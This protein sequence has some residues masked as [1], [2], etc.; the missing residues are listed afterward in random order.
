MT[1]AAIIVSCPK[2]GEPP[3][4]TDPGA[5]LEYDPRQ[6]RP[7]IG[8]RPMSDPKPLLG[9][10]NATNRDNLEMAANEA[11]LVAKLEL[12][13][14]FAQAAGLYAMA[15]AIAAVNDQANAPDDPD[16]QK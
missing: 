11:F 6:G 8:D 15:V 14:A 7:V 5:I 10:D 12:A 3:N 2:C 16:D 1:R 9:S 4:P 13:A